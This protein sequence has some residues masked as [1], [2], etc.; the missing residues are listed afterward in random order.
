MSKRKG[1]R[2]RTGTCCVVGKDEV[3]R[4]FREFLGGV[5]EGRPHRRTAFQ[6]ERSDTTTKVRC[7]CRIV[8]LLMPKAVGI[9]QEFAQIR[10]LAVSQLP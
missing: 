4:V 3:P 8:R 1:R 10:C 9:R 7:S 5:V 2:Y 6:A